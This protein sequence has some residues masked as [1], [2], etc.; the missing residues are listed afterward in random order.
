MTGLAMT[1]TEN[2][3]QQRSPALL[4]RAPVVV[5]ALFLLAVTVV[6]VR[7]IGDSDTWWHLRL[8]EELAHT[9]ALADP[10]AWTR[11]ATES[12]IATQWLPEV[13][14]A[15]WSG[16][17]GLPGLVWLVCATVLVLAVCLYVVCRRE[18]GLLPAALATI[19]GFGG[20]AA[21]LT[22]R[23][24][25]VSFVLL[26]VT[27][28]AWLQTARDLR[29][30]WWLVPVSWVWACCHGLWF[31][32]VVLGAVVVAGLVL[33]RR[34]GGRTALTLFLI[35]V[36]SVVAAAVTPVGQRLLLAPFA[37]GRI[38]EFVTEWQ[39]PSFF[40]LGP[41]LT[42]AMIAAVVVLGARSRG[43][44]SWVSIGLLILAAAW[45]LLSVRT[46]TLGA[47]IAAPL[48]AGA[49][50]QVVP[51]RQTGPAA[52]SRGE[53]LVV[54][55]S[56]AVCFVVA[57]LLAAVLP[58]V[59]VPANVPTGLDGALDRLPAHTVIWN[60]YNLGGWIDYRHPTLEVVADGRAEAFGAAQLEKY[61]RVVRTE[62]GWEEILHASGARVA[63]VGT[64]SPLAPALQ[65]R[66][67]WRPLGQADGY[68]LLSDGALI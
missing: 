17:F 1:T 47:A 23:P 66:L 20:M 57:A 59:R 31:S 41:A 51:R 65:E 60:D 2:P 63:L 18:A 16:W 48:L 14:A 4:R 38:T 45:T 5:F 33:D 30:R 32:G 29:P 54:G 61:G 42:A 22:P 26:V 50:D 37:V 64:D 27:L 10:P 62:P 6:F 39:R 56:A 34:A 35:P 40:D 55:S 43:R 15:R 58:S 21:T 28:G 68:V 8:G 53:K 7:P 25:L 49:L 36:L 11:F 9:W 19:L 24:Q 13:V 46:V 12:W 3:T 44:A 67:G 52:P